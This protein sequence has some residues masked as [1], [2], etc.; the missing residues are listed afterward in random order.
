MR[1]TASI[2]VILG[3]TA[4]GKTSIGIELAKL[5]G[6]EI[7]SVD[8]RKVYKGL[9][10][11][12][13]T[14][15]GEWKNKT[16]VVQ[17]IPHHLIGYLAPDQ[18]YTAGDFFLDAEK[19]LEDIVA[20]NR[21]PLLVG[22]TGF[23]FK[24]LEQGLP[25]LPKRDETIRVELEK[26]ILERG[27]PALHA[28]LAL[29]D[30]SA[31]N[32]ISPHDKHKVIRAL[33]IIHLTGQPFSSWKEKPR[34][35]STHQFVVMGLSWPKA[36]LDKRI[37]SRSKTMEKR[38]M[39][40]ETEAVLK[41]GYSHDCPALASFG[42]R[43]AVQVLEGKLPRKEFLPRLIHGTK[44]YAK[45]Q[46]TWFRTQTHPLWFDCDSSSQIEEISLK[47]KAFLDTAQP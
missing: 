19:L 14:P 11:G 5:I 25:V 45:R 13:A 32:A 8:S 4:S 43:E 44:S 46:R 27:V 21:R 2:P 35:R 24:A 36:E 3:P 16:L 1:K 23:Y 18:A 26:K 9:T 20:R 37:E 6:G 28:E 42:Y 47:M 17:G 7:I 10:I 34:R 31:A 33:E 12:T 40:E 30:A 41:Q 29:K 15:A 22:G 39:I 38:G